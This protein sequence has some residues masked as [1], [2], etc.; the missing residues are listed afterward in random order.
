MGELIPFPSKPNATKRITLPMRP[1]F[2]GHPPQ[3]QEIRSKNIELKP[4]LDQKIVN[5]ELERLESNHTRYREE[6]GEQ[7][8]G[9]LG[10]LEEAITKGKYSWIL[11]NEDRGQIQGMIA[12]KITEGLNSSGKSIPVLFVKN[13]T[14]CGSNYKVN[15][16]EK[17]EMVKLINNT[18]KPGRVLVVN[19]EAFGGHPLVGIHELLKELNIDHDVVSFGISYEPSYGFSESDSEDEDVQEEVEPEWPKMKQIGKDGGYEITEEDGYKWYLGAQQTAAISSDYHSGR[20][21]SDFNSLTTTPG[22]HKGAREMAE[23]TRIF[24][25]HV[26]SDV[27]EKYKAEH[28]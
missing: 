25:E 18:K 6:T 21:G 1:G 4:S 20:D 23:A 19:D 9:L 22:K 8:Y 27:L 14:L 26:A 12:Q 16:D 5:E 13:R 2:E 17:E 7:A 15:S 28:A 10:A 11:A 3:N 24:V